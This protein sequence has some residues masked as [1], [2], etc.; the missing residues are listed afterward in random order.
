MTN[1]AP[2]PALALRV[3]GHPLAEIAQQLGHH[4]LEATTRQIRA[5]LAGTPYAHLPELWAVLLLRL[6]ALADVL[7][8]HIPT[9]DREQQHA[10]RLLHDIKRQKAAT[11]AGMLHRLQQA[12]RGRQIHTARGGRP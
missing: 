10:A 9:S 8:A 4:D 6:D 5:E 2:G 7:R 11:L 1:T 3:A 12:D